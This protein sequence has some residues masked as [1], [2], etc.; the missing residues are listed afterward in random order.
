MRPTIGCLRRPTGSCST[1]LRRHRPGTAPTL[2]Q[3]CPDTA[4][5]LFET[6]ILRHSAGLKP[7]PEREKTSDC[8]SVSIW[9]RTLMP[10]CGRRAP[11]RCRR[12]LRSAN[13]CGATSAHGADECPSARAAVPARPRAPL[14]SCA[15]MPSSGSSRGHCMCARRRG[16]WG[17]QGRRKVALPR[18][19]Q[20]NC[21][22]TTAYP[23]SCCY[24]YQ[25]LR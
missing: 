24:S 3:H 18:V 2:P 9:L 6:T 1:L 25:P 23:S 14:P 17:Y 13:A 4:P 15:G 7:P 19:A 22:A 12:R 10:S 5:T 16:W 21:A 8:Q 20:P 11:W